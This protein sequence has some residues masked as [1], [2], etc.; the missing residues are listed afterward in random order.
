VNRLIKE[1]L[2]GGQSVFVAQSIVVRKTGDNVSHD[3]ESG[4]CVDVEDSDADDKAAVS[5]QLQQ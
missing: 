1:R 4:D 2:E 5:Q 3:L